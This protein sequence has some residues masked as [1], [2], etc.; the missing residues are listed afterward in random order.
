[1]LDE[2]DYTEA[3]LLLLAAL[4][5]EV[6]LLLRAD[7]DFYLD[8]LHNVGFGLCRKVLVIPVGQLVGLFGHLDPAVILSHSKSTISLLKILCAFKYIQ[9][10]TLMVIGFKTKLFIF[11]NYI[12]LLR[13]D[14]IPEHEFNIFDIH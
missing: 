4:V 11:S 3:H 12:I 7:P 6:L 8:F 13:V 9:A 2:L 5:R 10:N 14:E 1:M